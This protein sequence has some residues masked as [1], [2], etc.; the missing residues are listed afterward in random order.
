MPYVLQIFDIPLRA[1]TQAER[2]YYNERLRT[3]PDWKSAPMPAEYLIHRFQVVDAPKGAPCP[4][5]KSYTARIHFTIKDEYLSEKDWN[6]PG[7][8]WQ[9][10]Q[11]A[12]IA[13]A[14]TWHAIDD[15]LEIATSDDGIDWA[16]FD[17]AMMATLNKYIADLET[18]PDHDSE[19]YEDRGEY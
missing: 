14:L 17:R 11:S 6:Y 7:S 2:I 15:A 16:V 1:Y 4:D 12:W 3:R 18:L 5:H 8:R 9:G 13:Q 10:L 19:C